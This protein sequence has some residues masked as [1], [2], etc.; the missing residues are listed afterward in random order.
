MGERER[1]MGAG[2]KAPAKASSVHAIP[3]LPD[4]PI[5][6]VPTGKV[7]RIWLAVGALVASA[8]VMRFAGR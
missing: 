6:I 7:A 2:Q 8:V 3:V 1:G 4:P 5:A